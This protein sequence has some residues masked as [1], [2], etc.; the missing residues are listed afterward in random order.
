MLQKGNEA[1]DKVIVEFPNMTLQQLNWKPAPSSWSI[2]QCLD[3]LVIADSSYFPALKKIFEGTYAMTIWER[4]SP[5][6]AI[7]GRI[8]VDKLQEH[9]KKKMKAPKVFRPSTSNIDI[10]IIERFYQHHD[11]FMD[12]IASCDNTDLDRTNITSP[13]IRFVTY[14]L[15]NAIKLLVRH[16][17]RHINQAIRVKQSKD[18][19]E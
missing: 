16:E 15:R 12:Y 11:I 9:A 5:F 1:K 7:C 6:S 4:W 3:H 13:A 14:N 8:L 17:H 2:A 10:G 18:F 19:P